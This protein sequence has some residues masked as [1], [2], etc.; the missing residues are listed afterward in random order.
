MI[1]T[2][3]RWL[4]VSRALWFLVLLGPAFADPARAQSRTEDSTKPEV[5]DAKAADKISVGGAVDDSFSIYGMPIPIVDPT[6]GHGAAVGVL[7]TFRL[8]P[9]DKVS[10]RSTVAAGAGYTDTQ[11]YAFGTAT[12]LYL[13][14]DRYRVDTLVGYGNANIKFYGIGSDSLFKNHPLDFNIHG[15]F[16]RANARVRVLDHFYIGPLAKYLDSTAHFDVLPGILR[17]HDLDYRLA[18][19]G[20]ISEYDSRDTS[21]S[22]HEGIY[23]TVELTRFDERIGSDFNFV[24]LDG[25]AADY[26]ELTPNLVLAGQARVAAASGN[27]PFFALPYI[28]L[29]G[30]PAGKYLNDVTWQAQAEL[31]WRVIWRIGVVAFAGVGQTAPNLDAFTDSKV[32]YSGG[33]GLRFIASESERVNLGIDYARASDGDSALYFRIGEAF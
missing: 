8:D 19:A 18:G 31:R 25:S 17:P 9:D 16:A 1:A 3:T 5:D 24:G 15:L 21:F 4:G 11:S 26:L 29:R 32:L 12:S 13:D 6:I 28:T 30:F 33:A 22:P 10:P 14:E 27:P 7:G 2:S 23:A 20:L